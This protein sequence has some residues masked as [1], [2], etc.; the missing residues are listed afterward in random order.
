[1]LIAGLGG[2]IITYAK[3]NAIN[4]TIIAS[5][6]DEAGKAYKTA[7]EA[8]ERG[9]KL[10][11]L[12][13]LQT[14][15]I[16]DLETQF[17]IRVPKVEQS[18]SSLQQAVQSSEYPQPIDEGDLRRATRKLPRSLRTVTLM[19][20]TDPVA[21]ASADKI[22]PPFSEFIAPFEVSIVKL[23]ASEFRGVIVC[24]NGAGDVKVGEALKTR[25]L[26]QKSNRERPPQNAG[27]WAGHV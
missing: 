8:K 26:C 5:L 12:S 20:L 22:L 3:N 27:K 1:M 11:A 24:Q 17:G 19:R 9:D 21:A 10:E 23:A 13:N 15:Q 25:Q 14:L 2:E 18:V 6:N 4:G 16:V 7:D